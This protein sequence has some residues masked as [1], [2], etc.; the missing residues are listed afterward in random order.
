MKNMKIITLTNL[1]DKIYQDSFEP[2]SK[3]YGNVLLFLDF[4]GVLHPLG[5]NKKLDFN[6]VFY[7]EQLLEEFPNVSIVISSSWADTHSLDE[8]KKLLP[9]ISKSIIG[10]VKEINRYNRD[11]CIK[12]WLGNTSLCR[13]Y[14]WVAVDDAAFFE[15]DSPVVW[16]DSL[17]GLTEESFNVLK[18]AISSPYEYKQHCLDKNWEE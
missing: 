18:R 15:K 5:L 2:K 4:D 16:C 10:K 1:Y 7:I 17:T 11:I 3:F 14:P 9:S 13:Y 12:A 6:K 8:L